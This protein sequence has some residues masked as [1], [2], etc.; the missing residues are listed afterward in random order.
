[1]LL[2]RLLLYS[3][4][5][6]H[7]LALGVSRCHDH[8]LVHQMSL[9][10]YKCRMSYLYM[11]FVLHRWLSTLAKGN[12]SYNDCS[13]WVLHCR[14]YRCLWLMDSHHWTFPLITCCCRNLPL[15][16]MTANARF[17]GKK[18]EK[19]VWS[20]TIARTNRKIHFVYKIKSWVHLLSK[21]VVPELFVRVHVS[22]ENLW[23]LWIL[24]DNFLSLKLSSLFYHE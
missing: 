16:V 18:P 20:R 10:R 8:M 2:L 17:A 22:S 9:Y 13:F 23:L 14:L 21:P 12:L 24:N 6:F 15:I 3:H 11:P 7:L 5:T 19:L 1:M 4:A